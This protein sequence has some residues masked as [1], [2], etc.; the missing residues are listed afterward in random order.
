MD[1]NDSELQKGVIYSIV[2]ECSYGKL[3]QRVWDDI[4]S[5]IESYPDF[6]IAKTYY[7]K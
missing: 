1:E 3:E 4:I 2:S 6:N 5:F 7:G